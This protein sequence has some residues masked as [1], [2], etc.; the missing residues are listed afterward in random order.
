MAVHG[1]SKLPSSKGSF[2]YGLRTRDLMATWHF[3][4][5]SNTSKRVQVQGPEGLVRLT[6]PYLGPK[7]GLHSLIA[8]PG[9]LNLR[10]LVPKTITSEV[11]ESEASDTG[12]L[13]PFGLSPTVNVRSRK[14]VQIE[15][16]GPD[17]SMF[18]YLD[19]PGN[20]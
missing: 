17:T 4:S 5:A 6:E 18:A 13:D 10:F 15:F 9:T 1:S 7:I 2:G 14:P 3:E 8:R 11:L 16:L 20:I 19:L 12:Y